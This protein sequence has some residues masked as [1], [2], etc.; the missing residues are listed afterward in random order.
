MAE[1]GVTRPTSRGDAI[2]MVIAGAV[3]IFLMVLGLWSFF[4]PQSF[5]DELAT[6]P[7]YNRH[8]LHD[9]G[10]FQIGLGASLL[11]SLVWRWDALFVALAAVGIGSVFHFVAH[12]LDDGLGGRSSDPFSLGI[13]AGV[14]VLA[15]AWRWAERLK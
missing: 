3:G 9:I 8:F 2:Q 1:T 6:F 12:V 10:A 14:I 4:D 11:V 5:Y 15:A 13:L 7:P